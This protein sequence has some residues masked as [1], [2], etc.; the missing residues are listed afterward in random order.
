M[1]QKK[2]SKGKKGVGDSRP[3]PE[4]R[5]PRKPA[6]PSAGEQA[7]T[8]ARQRAQKMQRERAAEERREQ[9]RARRD[10]ARKRTYTVKAGDSLSKIAKDLLG[11]A[12]R[13]PEIFEANKDKLDDPNVIHPGQE[14]AIPSN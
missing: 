5:Q 3:A 9:I 2:P 12:N 7:A 14:L 8:Q 6:T 10:A 11:D 4:V 13:W 1:A